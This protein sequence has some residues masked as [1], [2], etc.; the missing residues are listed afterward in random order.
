MHRCWESAIKTWRGLNS[1]FS[2]DAQID[3]SP[4]HRWKHRPA[5][6]T[7][8]RLIDRQS[9]RHKSPTSDV[10]QIPMTVSA[11]SVGTW[12]Q[13]NTQQRLCFGTYHESA[14]KLLISSLR[15]YDGSW[16][17]YVFIIMCRSCYVNNA[18]C[19]WCCDFMSY[20]IINVDIVWWHWHLLM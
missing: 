2:R 1:S 4:H 10:P 7:T 8:N 3:A 17:C 20:S 9:A 14:Q 11:H 15:C 12:S 5:S 18:I 6:A 13:L 19:Q 16:L